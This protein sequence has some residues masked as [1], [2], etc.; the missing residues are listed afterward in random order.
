MQILKTSITQ[1]VIEYLKKNIESGVWAV[2]E[3]I[4]SEN[5]LSEILGVSRASIRVAVQQFIALEVLESIQ[6]KGTYVRTN[7]IAG[8]SSDFNAINESNYDDI[9]QVLEFRR[10]IEPE[11]AYIAAQRASSTTINNL[12]IYLKNMKNSIGQ[13]EEFV[14]QDMLFHEEISRATG[15]RLLE[16]CLKEVFQQKAKNHKQINEAFGFND[17]IYY[18]TLLLEAIETK[19]F[20]KARKLMKEHLQQAIERLEKE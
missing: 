20:R 12:K 2:G 8:V 13:S 1:Q 16:K 18:H 4:P 17:G 3:K 15:N 14:K 9:M 10:V 11:C 19:N 6:G 7:N 5:N